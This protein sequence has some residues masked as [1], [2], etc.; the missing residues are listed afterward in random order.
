MPTTTS[1][2]WKDTYYT[3]STNS[4]TYFITLDGNTIYSGK[5]VKNPDAAGIEINLNKVCRNYLS[6]NIDT[7]L[8]SHGTITSETN[9]LAERTFKL[10]VNGSNVMDYKFY[11]DWSYDMDAPTQNLSMPING[12]YVPGMLT[13]NTVRSSSYVTSISNINYNKQV[14]CSPY[15]LYYLNAY[16]GWDSFL[17][18]GTVKKKNTFTT[19]QTDKV[20]KNTSIEFETNKYV[21]EIKTS[22]ELNTGWLNDEQSANLSKNLMGSLRVYLHDIQ[23]DIIK[24]VII[25]DENVSYQTYQTNGKKLCQYKINITESQSKV[26]K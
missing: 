8:S 26:R 10:Y 1:P 6:C 24:P 9:N 5:A 13:L 7:I 17:I 4:A 2:I 18:E 12:H 11:M 22:Y 15:A 21:Q 14:K 3:A 20:F 19:Y 16:G 23:N 25:T